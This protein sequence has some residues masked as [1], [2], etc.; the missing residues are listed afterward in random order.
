MMILPFNSKAGSYTITL[1]SVVVNFTTKYSYSAKCWV[2]D[3]LDTED[4]PILS[5][6]M[7]VPKVDLLF[8]YPT[9]AAYLGGLVVFEPT[10]QQGNY[11]SPDALG[12]GFWVVWFSPEEE[13]I[14]Q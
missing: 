4:N 11:Q 13:V 2:L 3:I 5:G 9:E 1:G 7:A 6:L 12:A 8:P 10:D 14:L